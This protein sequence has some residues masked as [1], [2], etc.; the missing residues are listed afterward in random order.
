MATAAPGAWN[1]NSQRNRGGSVLG[2]PLG[3][4]IFTICFSPQRRRHHRKRVSR[5]RTPIYFVARANLEERKHRHSTDK[6]TCCP[7]GCFSQQ[8]RRRTADDGQCARPDKRRA[9]SH[10][11]PSGDHDETSHVE[12]VSKQLQPQRGRGRLPVLCLGRVPGPRSLPTMR[13]AGVTAKAEHRRKGVG[14]ED[15]EEKGWCNR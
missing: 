5:E 11:S 9:T 3:E 6:D 15:R 12:M 2:A 7:L 13:D 8:T 10:D 14:V 1:G 4:F